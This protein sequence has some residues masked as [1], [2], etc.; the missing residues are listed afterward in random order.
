M[1]DQDD[2]EKE[3]KTEEPSE[4][5]MRDAIEKGQVAQSKE[6]AI[7]FNLLVGAT[8]IFLI[9][10]SGTLNVTGQLGMLMERAAFTS[11]DTV[12]DLQTV[13]RQA[14][15]L[16]FFTAAPVFIAFMLSGLMANL[17]QNPP[18][19]VFDR[20][21]P[22][23][24]RISLIKG[25]ER[26]FSVKGFVEFFKSTAKVGTGVA[27]AVFVLSDAPERLTEMLQTH[28]VASLQ[29]MQT[30]M[31]GIFL[32][33]ALM[34]AIIAAADYFWSRHTWRQ[35]LRMTPKEL[36]DEAKETMGDPFL[37][38]KQRSVATDRA[39][40]RMM[41]T[42][43]L[44]T[45]IVANPTHFSVALRY[46]SDQDSAPVV[47]AKGQDLVALKIREIAAEHDVPVFE[48]V[49]LARGLYKAV[50]VDQIIP[51][52]FFGPVAELIALVRNQSA[53]QKIA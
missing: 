9:G 3:D 10:A 50:A 33:V 41:Q 19:V 14:T 48:N 34:M 37:K 24:S 51:H 30:Y 5:K 49:D 13:T 26:I 25:W 46:E 8:L 47:V 53:K 32:A 28:P 17:V 42:V 36:K 45:L 6:V 43:P 12:G 44:A 21:K 15:A 18:S 31:A 29:T 7:F 40:S 22:Q 16:I 39:R 35:D 2:T 11:L 27:V 23:L 38:A 20:V 1:A 52:E 4:K